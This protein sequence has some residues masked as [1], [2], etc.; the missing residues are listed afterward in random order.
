[1]KKMNIKKVFALITSVVIATT[2]MLVFTFSASATIHQEHFSGSKYYNYSPNSYRLYLD[3]FKGK[4]LFISPKCAR[5]SVLDI[6][7]NGY[8][9]GTNCWLYKLNYSFAQQFT[10]QYVGLDRFGEYFII[11]K[12][13]TKNMVLDVSGGIVRNGQN[14]QLY[15]HNGTRAQQ[16]YIRKAQTGYYYIESRLNPDYVMDVS[17]ASP[18][19]CTNIH[20]W[21]KNGTNAQ[22]FS[23]N[24]C[25]HSNK[26]RFS[27][28]T[29]DWTD[30]I[31]VA[32]W[33]CKDCHAVLSHG[34]WTLP[35]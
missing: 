9:N 5:N 20:L 13:N 35:N 28:L 7:S 33:E 22:L 15:Q 8:R 18:N 27:L 19:N 21:K 1:M 32:G 2:M 26:R 10:L 14:I 6:Q 16:W 4:L 3:E 12:A 23:F 29:N 30:M 25:D 24:T 31:W 11:R 34:T 17:N